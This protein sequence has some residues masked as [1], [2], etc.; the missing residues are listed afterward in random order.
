MSSKL[1]IGE[2]L[3]VAI[4]RI[5]PRGFGI[6]FAEGLTIFVALAAAGDRARVRITEMKGSVAFAEIEEIVSPSPERIVPPC[7]YFGTCGGCDFQQMNYTAQLNAKVAIVRDCLHRI[8]KIEFEDIKIIPSPV[9]FGYRSRAQWHIDAGKK[10]IGYYRRNS[11]DLVDIERCIVLDPSLQRELE[12]LRSNLEWENIW[13]PKA[14]ID[15]AVGDDGKVSVY[16]GEL[17]PDPAEISFS[18]GED[19]FHYSAKS[20]FQG[21]QHLIPALLET[22]LSGADGKTAL[23]LYCGAGLFTLPLAR[24]FESVIGVEENPAAVRSGQKNADASRLTNIKFLTENVR[25]FVARGEVGNV[26]FVLLDPPRFGTEKDTVQNIIEMN[27]KQ[28]SYVACE[29]SVLARDLKRFVENGYRID[30][31]TALDLFPQTHH[32]ETVARLSKA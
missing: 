25:R 23:D 19:T 15:A 24:W 26:D 30:S 17:F 1:K 22:A 32:V 3:D 11:R 4:E 18:S 29:P 10:Q 12:K 14:Q 28:V 6:A 13:S 5:V 8:G 9:E 16:S 27:A 7:V 2:L 21:N 20:F 31:I